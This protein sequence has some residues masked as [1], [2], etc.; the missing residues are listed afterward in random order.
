MQIPEHL[1]TFRD[2]NILLLVAGKQNAALYH[3]HDGAIDETFKVGVERPHYSDNEGIYQAAPNS[4]VL[5]G[6]A[7]IRQD[8]NV[9]RDFLKELDIKIKGLQGTF[10]ELYLLAPSMSRNWIKESL[11][12]SWQEKLVLEKEGNYMKE[13]PLALLEMLAT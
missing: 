1:S 13:H 12:R 5:T 2:K 10:E 11:P 3:I 8:E 6:S 7:E 4:R 9:I